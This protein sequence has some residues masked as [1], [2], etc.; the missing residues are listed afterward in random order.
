[1]DLVRLRCVLRLK[2]ARDDQLP[3]LGVFGFVYR[4]VSLAGDPHHQP[5]ESEPDQSDSDER[6]DRGKSARLNLNR[7]D[8]GI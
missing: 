8:A 3:K 5:R 4:A 2:L 1:M 7:Y 6:D